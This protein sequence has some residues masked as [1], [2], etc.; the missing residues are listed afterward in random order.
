M[1]CA[2]HLGDVL[3]DPDDLDHVELRIPYLKVFVKDPPVYV[4]N[5]GSTDRW[6]GRNI[7][8]IPSSAY[9]MDIE[10]Q[11]TVY[12]KS[13]NGGI[14]ASRM[15]SVKDA[16]ETGASGQFSGPEGK[17]EEYIALCKKVLD[18]IN[19]NAEKVS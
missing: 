15:Y 5:A 11:Y 10:V 2:L 6:I 14:Y 12:L 13:F 4:W 17:S 18:S 16:A 8:S 1:W 9:T 7:L 19:S 3:K